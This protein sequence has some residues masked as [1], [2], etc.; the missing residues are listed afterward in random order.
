MVI[1]SYIIKVCQN[2][3]LSNLKTVFLLSYGSDLDHNTINFLVKERL[4]P[5]ARGKGNK[6]NMKV[7]RHPEIILIYDVYDVN[8]N[9]HVDNK[10]YVVDGWK[11]IVANSAAVNFIN[12]SIILFVSGILLFI[13]GLLAG[14]RKA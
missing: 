9:K 7:S 1:S 10:Y 13:I 11:S 8:L 2:G 4:K 6:L 14:R 5:Y 12:G 3:V